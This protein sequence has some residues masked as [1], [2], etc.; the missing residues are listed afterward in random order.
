MVARIFIVVLLCLSPLIGQAHSKT[1]VITLV[2][3]NDITGEIKQLL[4][5][6][7]S[8][9][10]DSMGTLQVEWEDVVAVNSEF[11]YEVRLKNGDRYYGSLSAGNEPGQVRI[12]DADG[13]QLVPVLE[14]VEL[15][16][17]E[18]T[19]ADRFDIR[20]GIGYSY[21]K[22]ADVGTLNLTSDVS[23]QDKNGVTGFDGR[24]SKT[25]QDGGSVG[26]NQY[27]ISRQFWTRRQQVIRWFEGSYEDNDELELDFRYTAGFG[28]GKALVD[29]NRQ[30]FI[31]FVGIQAASERGFEADRLQSVEGV[32]GVTYNLWR[33]DTPELDLDTDFTVYPS[34][35]E[36]G[37]W[38]GNANIRL[39]WELVKDLYWDVTYWSTYDNRSQSGTDSDYGVSIGLAWHN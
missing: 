36:S 9:G 20:L 3:G 16:V 1:D 27:T 18:A 33:F 12:L 34:I 25:R 22:A 10:T 26:S 24:T 13:E 21:A 11:E 30:S 31:G 39:S 29:T 6:S 5:G 23:Y 28:L 37:R 15:R 2:N 14:V 19:V 7:L 17:L 32:F 38:R 35:T 8:F 4:R